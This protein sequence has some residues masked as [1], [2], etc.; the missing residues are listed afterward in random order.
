MALAIPPPASPTGLGR[1]VKK[2][3]FTA[4]APW[5]SEEAEDEEQG[6]HGTAGRQPGCTVRHRALTARR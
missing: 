4:D 3:R 1:W 2:S 6:R 5:Y